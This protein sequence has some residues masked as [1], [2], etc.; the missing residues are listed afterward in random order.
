MGMPFRVYCGIIPWLRMT[1]MFKMGSYS[2]V[3]AL[4]MQAWYACDLLVSLKDGQWKQNTLIVPAS[5][6]VK[7]IS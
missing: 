5:V 4:H 7:T 2:D 3:G 1:F 6:V